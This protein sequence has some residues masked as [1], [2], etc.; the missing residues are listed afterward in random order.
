MKSLDNY[1]LQSLDEHIGHQLVAVIVGMKSHI[2]RKPCKI[3]VAATEAEEISYR[4]R[5]VFGDLTDQLGVLF[6]IDAFFLSLG[7]FFYI[8][9]VSRR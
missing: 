2:D 5:L 8:I 9:P 3:V 4:H 6:E 7:V 1:F